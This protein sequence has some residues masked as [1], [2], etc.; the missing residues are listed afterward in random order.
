[1]ADNRPNGSL[2]GL[3]IEDIELA[4]GW[5]GKRGLLIKTLR[6]VRYLDGEK[7]NYNIHDWSEHNPWAASRGMRVEVAKRAARIRWERAT[8]AEIMPDACGAHAE[9]M[10]D[11]MRNDAHTP[12]EQCP[13][14]NPTQPNPTQP[15][16]T[17]PNHKDFCAEPEKSPDSTPAIAGTLPLNDGSRH[18]V[19]EP[20]VAEWQAL[21]PAV[22][23]RQELRG[24]QGWL[25]GNPTNRKTKRGI[26]RFINTW[27]SKEQDKARSNGNGSTRTTSKA[28]QR[29]AH[30]LEVANAVLRNRHGSIEM[31]DGELRA[32]RVGASQSGNDGNLAGGP[33]ILPP[34]RD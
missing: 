29:T 5:K 12:K 14:P 26:N 2:V 33:K 31:A 15:N 17:T 22:D 30:N 4:A 16:P 24:M 34:G 28:E 25:K 20:E 23:V 1:V 19:T 6:E 10:P 13:P 7:G 18:P 11:A 27:L 9:R 3:S 21:Y 32:K 8:G